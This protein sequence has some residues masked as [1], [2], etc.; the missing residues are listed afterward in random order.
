MLT[1]I[2]DFCTHF[3]HHFNTI[4]LST[5]FLES[6]LQW[7]WL[8]SH[9]SKTEPTLARWLK[10][11]KFFTSLA[12]VIRF[13]FTAWA[14]YLCT[15]R[16]SNSVLT[17]MYSCITITK[18]IDMLIIYYVIGRPNKSFYPRSISP[19]SIY[20]ILP[21]LHFTTSLRL[22]KYSINILFSSSS[23]YFLIFSL[24]FSYA[25]GFNI[26]LTKLSIIKYL[27]QGLLNGLFCL[28]AL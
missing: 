17:H 11:L 16:A 10:F 23:F 4:I 28:S 9:G 6:W 8:F 21:H 14:E 24:S 5:N 27:Q 12:L 26:S 1:F 25:R 3:F 20:I 18:F 19:C 15:F 2:V 7:N 13:W 22:L